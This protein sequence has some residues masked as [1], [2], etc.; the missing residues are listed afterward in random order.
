[1]TLGDWS[2]R[3][4]N[5]PKWRVFCLAIAITQAFALPLIRLPAPSPR[6]DGEKADVANAFANRHSWRNG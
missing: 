6:K 4:E 2:Y 3:F 1:L 5:P